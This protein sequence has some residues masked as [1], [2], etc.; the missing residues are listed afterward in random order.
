MQSNTLVDA[1]NQ[2]H[3]FP[4]H[5]ERVFSVLPV[6][7]ASDEK[8][9][10]NKLEAEVCAEEG[11][12]DQHVVKGERRETATLT[13]WSQVGG[14][15]KTAQEDTDIS[16]LFKELHK[17]GF[18]HKRGCLGR[19]AGLNWS[20]TTSVIQEIQFLKL[21]EACHTLRASKDILAG[22]MIF[23]RPVFWV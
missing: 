2:L 7:L 22:E 6:K 1:D 17:G 20:V 11:N 3:P 10:D 14:S 9:R 21:H 5:N 13:G 4:D 23:Q 19:N 18:F 12:K 8:R 16:G 15:H